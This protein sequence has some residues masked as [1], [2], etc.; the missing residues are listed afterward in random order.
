MEDS[1]WFV[2]EYIQVFLITSWKGILFINIWTRHQ[3]KT[4]EHTVVTGSNNIFTLGVSV[5]ER[6]N[7]VKSQA[8]AGHGTVS[9]R[10]GLIKKKR[11][12]KSFI[13]NCR[14]VRKFTHNSSCANKRQLPQRYHGIFPTIAQVQT[15]LRVINLVLIIELGIRCQVHF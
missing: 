12:K 13:G 11:F 2:V 5:S 3:L 8:F 15:Q 1:S 10:R 7:K 9:V 4:N 6:Y 14:C